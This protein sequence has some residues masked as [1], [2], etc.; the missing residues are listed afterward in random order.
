MLD[1][2]AY[3]LRFAHH[4]PCGFVAYTEKTHATSRQIVDEIWV[5]EKLIID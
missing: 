3:A 1:F 4:A 2:Y 5:Y